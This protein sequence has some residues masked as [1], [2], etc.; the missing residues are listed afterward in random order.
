MTGR[1]A[2]RLKT[3]RKIVPPSTWTVCAWAGRFAFVSFE[4]LTPVFL[5]PQTYEFLGNGDWCCGSPCAYH[6]HPIRTSAIRVSARPAD[7]RAARVAPECNKPA[8]RHR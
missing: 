6:G 2:A 1:R 7:R 5:N 4:R 8:E 3:A